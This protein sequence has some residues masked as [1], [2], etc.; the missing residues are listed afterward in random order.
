MSKLIHLKHRMKAIRVIKKITHAMRLISMSSHTKLKKN[1]AQ[2]KAIKNEITPILCQ[3]YKNQPEVYILNEDAFYDNLYIVIGSEKGLCGNFNNLLHT[4]LEK[5]I[6][7]EIAKKSHFIVVGKKAQRYFEEKKIP[8][9][10]TFDKIQTGKID[11][12]ATSLFEF[13][14][15]KFD[16]YKSIK[17]IHNNPKSFFT[18]VPTNTTLIPVQPESCDTNNASLDEYVWIQSK[19][20]VAAIL[21]KTLLKTNIFALLTSSMIAEQSS[22]FLSMDSSTRNADSLLKSMT[23]EYNKARQAIITREIIELVASF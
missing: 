3:L 15:S 6:S 21:F 18:I 19:K 4:F 17:C 10:L 1:I 23:L 22:R 13:I 20:E 11:R 16:Q 8:M 5:E 12:V 7:E 9:L 14:E 2:L